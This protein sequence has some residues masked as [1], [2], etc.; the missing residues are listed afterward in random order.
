MITRH[1]GKGKP[2]EQKTDYQLTGAGDGGKLQWSTMELG[3][4]MELFQIL[5]SGYTTTSIC[6]N[7]QSTKKVNFTEFKLS[8]LYLILAMAKTPGAANTSWEVVL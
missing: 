5:K 7:S 3:G 8:E 6:Q 1:F 2:Q 4:V